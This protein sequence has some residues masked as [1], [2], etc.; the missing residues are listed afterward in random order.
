MKKPIPR[1][2][3]EKTKLAGGV[4]LEKEYLVLLD[5]INATETVLDLE[6]GVG[7]VSEH[8]A[9]LSCKVTLQEVNRLA[10]S[11][12]RNIVPN[13]KVTPWNIDASSIKLDKPSYDHVILRNAGNLGLAKKLAKK[14]IINL[15]SMEVEHVLPNIKTPEATPKAIRDNK[16]TKKVEPNHLLSATTTPQPKVTSVPNDE[17]MESME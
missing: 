11:F 7:L 1:I 4:P 17:P 3:I 14:S 10:F 16:S 2:E 15:F 12:R 13:S 8:L 5:H 9:N 6:G